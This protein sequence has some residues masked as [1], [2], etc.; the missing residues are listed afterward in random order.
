[1][2]RAR[3]IA[4]NAWHFPPVDVATANRPAACAGK[5]Q[6]WHRGVNLGEELIGWLT[7]SGADWGLGMRNGGWG[8]DGAVCLVGPVLTGRVTPPESIWR[9]A[10]FAGPYFK[11]ARMADLV[12]YVSQ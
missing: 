10:G 6:A 4:G 3:G 9:L 2:V 11:F 8:I 5:R 12:L 1:M 7:L